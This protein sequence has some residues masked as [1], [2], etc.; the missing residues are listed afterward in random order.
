[1]RGIT[2]ARLF[3]L[4]RQKGKVG[5]KQ[6]Q[7]SNSAMKSSPTATVMSLPFLK[8]AIHISGY[9]K[10]ITTKWLRFWPIRFQRLSARKVNTGA[11]V[12]FQKNSALTL[13]STQVSR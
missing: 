2:R 4:M 3:G 13:H 9:L 6:Y 8:L 7:A 1:M 12:E 5:T 10:N 11:C